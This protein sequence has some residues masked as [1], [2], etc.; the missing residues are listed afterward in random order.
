VSKCVEYYGYNKLFI[1]HK[2]QGIQRCIY[3]LATVAME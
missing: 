2:L 1:S 3:H